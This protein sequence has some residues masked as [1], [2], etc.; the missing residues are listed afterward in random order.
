MSDRVEKAVTFIEAVRESLAGA[1]R[2]NSGDSVP[3]AAVLWT[4]ADGE[5]RPIAERLRGLVPELVEQRLR[6]KFHGTA[7]TI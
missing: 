6:E 7:A 3:P 5:W 4:D 1:T 2:Y